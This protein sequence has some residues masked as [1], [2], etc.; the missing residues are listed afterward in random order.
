[1][2]RSPLCR[3]SALLP[4]VL[5]GAVAAALLCGSASS[6]RGAL[7][8]GL[9]ARIE[10]ARGV[11]LARL[12][13]RQAPMTVGNFVG[14]AEGRMHWRDPADGQIKT[15]PFYDGLTFHRVVPGFV[16]QGG[17]PIGNGTGGPGYVF[18]DEFSPELRHNR[19]GV[20][21]MANAGPN[22]NGSQFFIT[23]KATPWLDGHHSVF[24]QVVQGLKVMGRIR[25]GDRIEHVKILRI[26]SAAKAFDALEAIRSKL[27]QIMP[28]QRRTH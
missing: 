15:R 16:I 17:D 23:F 9:Y 8:D 10:T 3:Q 19:A 13:Y 5:L 26:G 11:I 18:P 7:P 25:P 1:M 6:V 28:A 24:G 20:V 2:S 22:T 14:L 4:V 12:Y 21:S 27:R